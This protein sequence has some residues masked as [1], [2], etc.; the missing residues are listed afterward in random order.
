MT[1]DKRTKTAW[2]KV[3][4][5]TTKYIL[6]GVEFTYIACEQCGSIYLAVKGD[7]FVVLD[8]LKAINK[9]RES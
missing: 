3:C 6:V 9:P 7:Q 2:C 5:K 8:E 4:K 1:D